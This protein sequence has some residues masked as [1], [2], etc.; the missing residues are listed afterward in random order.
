M[1]LQEKFE[2]CASGVLE[3]PDIRQVIEL[4]QDMA[5]VEDIGRLMDVLMA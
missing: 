2:D 5:Q 1:A 3:R 4:V